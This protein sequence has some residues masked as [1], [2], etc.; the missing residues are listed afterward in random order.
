M[1]QSGGWGFFLSLL[2][3]FLDFVEYIQRT[4]CMYGRVLVHSSAMTKGI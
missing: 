4:H 2:N 1:L 3:W